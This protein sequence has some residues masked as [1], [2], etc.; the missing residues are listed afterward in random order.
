MHL[1]LSVVF[2]LV[3]APV[4]ALHSFAAEYDLTRG[5]LRVGVMNRQ[6]RI[7]ADQRYVFESKMETRGLVALFARRRIVETSTGRVKN[8]RLI[9]ERYSFDKRDN[10]KDYGLVFDYGAN[11]VQRVD[12]ARPW[13]A[14]LPPGVL[15]KLSYQAQMMVD[16]AAA[17]QSLHYVVAG[18]NDLDDYDIVN[19]GRDRVEIELGT[20]DTVVLERR[21]TGSKR[22]TTV[23]LA[24][25]LAWMPVKVE[26]VEKDGDLT[27]ARLRTLRNL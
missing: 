7:S 13:R 24:E 11:E 27:T 22:R 23:W 8:Q 18:R 25:K 15:D 14:P 19:R 3:A 26:Y 5:S 16:I 20:F 9:P 2:L 17:P 6:L 21:K 1:L 12:G 10:R 4:S